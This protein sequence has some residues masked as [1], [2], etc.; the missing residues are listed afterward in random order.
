MQKPEPKLQPNHTEGS[1]GQEGPNAKP[2]DVLHDLKTMVS[3]LPQEISFF[4]GHLASLDICMK[5]IHHNMLLKVQTDI[6]EAGV[7][8]QKVSCALCQLSTLQNLHTAVDTQ[9]KV[10]LASVYS[11]TRCKAE[12]SVL[13]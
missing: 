9:G 7:V 12:S 6:K 11:P 2:P 10:A 8:A 1:A 5:G 3:C 13:R 4:S